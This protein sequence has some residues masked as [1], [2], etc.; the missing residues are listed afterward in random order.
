MGMG[1]VSVGA[2]IAQLA[3]PVLLLVGWMR[4]ELGPKGAGVCLALAAAAWFGLP[5]LIPNGEWF[6]TPALALLDIALVLVVFK[7]DLRIG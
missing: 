7:G 1:S 5:R 2:W 4:D 6:V 3:L